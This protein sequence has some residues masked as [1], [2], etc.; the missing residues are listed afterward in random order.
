MSVCQ[1][2]VIQLAQIAGRAQILPRLAVDVAGVTCRRWLLR[3]L[4]LLASLTLG[5]SCLNSVLNLT[6]Q[7][8]AKAV[9][10]H[11]VAALP[12]D[13][14]QFTVIQLAQIL[15]RAQILPRLAIDVAGVTC[16]RLLRLLRLLGLLASLTL[17]RCIL[18]R[19]AHLVLQPPRKPS[20]CNSARPCRIAAH[21]L[22]VVQLAQI[23][24]GAQ[25][26]TRLAIDVAA[27][28]GPLLLRL[29]G[30]LL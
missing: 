6:P 25:I 16:R 15:R 19:I 2:A 8:A 26:L 23:A 18:N 1:L 13:V 4:G 11:Q 7:V 12:D 20:C 3:L 24:A 10:L 5:N 9:L 30:L 22:T 17:S 28:T 27:V 14:G 29:L 21:Q